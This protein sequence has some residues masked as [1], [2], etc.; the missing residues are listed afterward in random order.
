MS[1]SGAALAPRPYA[2]VPP[3]PPPAFIVSD[4]FY[5]KRNMVFRN[6]KNRTTQYALVPP[7]LSFA[8]PLLDKPT[9]S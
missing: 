5:K 1:E 7:I 4:T 6:R 8:L 9:P 3:I 2:L